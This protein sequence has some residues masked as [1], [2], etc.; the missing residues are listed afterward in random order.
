M[1][2]H[3][4]II[5][6]TMK[7]YYK[8][9]RQITLATVMSVSAMTAMA[10]GDAA[11][12]IKAGTADANK[13]MNGYASPMLKAFGSGLNGGWFQTAKPHGIGG[14]DITI[15]GNL[16]F[17]PSADQSYNVNDLH[18]QKVRLKAGE[19]ADAPT[20][21]GSS[22]DGPEV[23]VYDK[24]PFTGQDTAI[25]SFK[26]PPGI[27]ASFFPM[28]T[29][30][31]AVGVGFGTE[32]AIRFI[33]TIKTSD[34]SVGLFGFAVKHD[35]KQWIPGIK[36]MPFDLSGMFGFTSMKSEVKFSGDQAIK[37][38]RNADGT[39]ISYMYY[40]D[41]SGNYD[42]Q[43]MELTSKAWTVNVLISKKLGPL[44][45]YLG[46]GYQKATTELNLLGV[47]PVT[48]PNDQTSATTPGDPAFLKATR[49]MDVKDPVSVTG[50]IGGMRATVGFRLKLAVLTIHGDYTFAEY[51]VASVG[52]GINL[53][54]IVPFKL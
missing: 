45:P 15:S 18:L 3:Y 23:E 43:K 38:E 6:T 30:Q 14:F 4:L 12:M 16:S 25:T 35:I 27:G 28:P 50:K 32:I 24:S 26:L 29:A 34:M 20:I 19:S 8:L 33:P 31:F 53:Q 13:L 41:A 36:E 52:V 1:K 54:S 17:A 46:L 2:N 49:I 37:P 9:T 11:A 7:N 40:G 42:D 21:F 47:Y 5:F 51:K 48:V 22:S 44:T 39:D 10:Q